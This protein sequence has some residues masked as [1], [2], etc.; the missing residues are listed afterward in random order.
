MSLKTN[1]NVYRPAP[2][3]RTP[4]A[5]RKDGA[6][7]RPN[8]PDT[9][10]SPDRTWQAL[11]G[12]VLVKTREHLHFQAAREVEVTVV[13]VTRPHVSPTRRQERIS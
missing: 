6:L 4:G 10:G 9:H 11:D 3:H 8:R 7:F 12:T 5:A 2:S 13:R 1:P